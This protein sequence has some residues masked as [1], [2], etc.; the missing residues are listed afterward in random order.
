MGVPLQ[1]SV[2]CERY[3][4]SCGGTSTKTKNKFLGFLFSFRN[5]EEIRRSLAAGVLR[6]L[7]C[8]AATL[9]WA[10]LVRVAVGQLPEAQLIKSP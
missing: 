9:S 8:E 10:V 3:M 6:G 1:R 2:G 5:K 7:A 4:V